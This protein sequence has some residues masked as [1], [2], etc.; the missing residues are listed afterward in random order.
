MSPFD[1][2]VARNK[3]QDQLGYGI[4]TDDEVKAA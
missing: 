2:V 3:M 4:D 1:M